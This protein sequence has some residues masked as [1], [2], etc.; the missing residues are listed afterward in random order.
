M[1]SFLFV[2]E[3]FTIGG[4]ET[5]LQGEMAY[6]SSL[7]HEV[8]LATGGSLIHSLLPEKLSSVTTSLNFS[9][10]PSVQSFCETV[11]RLRFLIRSMNVSCVLVHPF[12]PSIPSFIAAALEGVSLKYTVHGPSS[13]NMQPYGYLVDFLFKHIF[14]PHVSEVVCVSE[15]SFELAQ[16]YLNSNCSIVPNAVGLPLGL[17]AKD[18]VDEVD[19]RWLVVSRLESDKVDG[20]F[21]FIVKA[22]KAGIVGVVIVGDGGQRE[23][24]QKKIAAVYLSEFVQ[25]YGF[26]ENAYTLMP[27]FSGVAGIGRVLLEGLFCKKP[28]CSI[29]NLGI[30]GL[31]SFENITIAAAANFSGRNLPVVDEDVFSEQLKAH[32]SSDALR[33][34][35]YVKQHYWDAVVWQKAYNVES[36]PLKDTLLTQLYFL[37][38][39]ESF[40]CEKECLLFSTHV[41]GLI[42]ELV[43]SPKYFTAQLSFA[44]EHAEKQ[45]TG[46]ESGLLT[47]GSQLITEM[48]S[49]LTEGLQLVAEMRSQL[50]EGL[51]LVAETRSQLT[52]ELQLLIET[53]GQFTEDLRLLIEARSQFVENLQLLTETRGRFTE[54]LQLLTEAKNHLAQELNTQKKLA[55]QELQNYM[56]QKNGLEQSLMHSQEQVAELEAKIHALLSSN[57]WQVTGPFR[58]VRRTMGGRTIKA[59]IRAVAKAIYTRLPLSHKNK[60]ALKNVLLGKRPVSAAMIKSQPTVPNHGVAYDFLLKNLENTESNVF[61]FAVIDW[62]FRMQRPQH[63]AKGLAQCGKRVFYFSN[64]FVN[65]AEPGYELERLDENAELYQIKLHVN[66]APAIYFAGPSQN[67][68]NSIN[69]SMSKFLIDFGIVSSIS[70]VQHA[71]WYPTANGLPNNFLMYDCMDHHEGFG[72]VPQEIIELEHKLL[73]T[74]NSVIT[75]SSWLEDFAKGHNPNVVTIRNA[76]EYGHFATPP[77]EVF[78]D[79]KGRKIIG[80]FGAIAEWFDVELVEKVARHFPDCLVL[81]IGNDTINAGKQLNAPNIELVGEVPYHKLPYY[82]HAFDVCLLPFLVIPLTLATNPVKVYEYLSAGKSVVSVDLPELSQFEGLVRVAATHDEFAHQIQLALNDMPLS[83]DVV[84]ARQ[85]FAQQQTWRLRTEKLLSYINNCQSPK[86]SIVVVT[87][88]N[89]E[90]T[91]NCLHS[92]D[93]YSDYAN[94]EIIVVDN[95][96][97]DGSDQFLKEWVLGANNRKLILNTDNKG[98]SAANNQGIALAS[99]EYCVLLNNDT[100]VTPGWIRT[101]LSCFQSDA[102]TGIVG[103]VTNN[104]GNEAKID[105]SYATMSEMLVQSML[106]TRHHIGSKKNLKVLAFFCV[107][108]SRKLVE[109]IGVLDEAFGQGFFEDDDYCRRAEQA[110]YRLVCAENVFVHHHLSASFNKLKQH[111]RQ[112]LFERNKQIYEAKWGEWLP[113]QHRG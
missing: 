22:K 93:R 60:Q 94:K 20:V 32:Q 77:Q 45:S 7:G 113:H 80:Y 87:Y 66:G 90:L 24:L 62:H 55:E 104:I 79:P 37:L 47:K 34:F 29:G 11:E 100:Y 70:I 92:I 51:Q 43:Y 6:L 42:G 14:L 26:K 106:F 65:S 78:V 40:N 59:R 13:L 84:Q 105:I 103:P 2:T 71:Y 36:A 39:Q 57:S 67:D 12:T 44:Y 3:Q 56:A 16:P 41:W 33:L 21:D 1:K 53:R 31:V 111:D 10:N 88:N 91:K 72:N 69:A 107:M 68:I 48:R 9:P 25:F 99:G 30:N 8:H 83:N 54:D 15:E 52:E 97:T 28:V 95:Q 61:V 18:K 96:S 74:S 17:D 5:R 4:V 109:E 108:F 85:H 76:T 64:H 81:L 49:Q 19:P 38:K 46:A 50:T 102:S 82:L 73:A 35:E 86:V 58:Y 101:M 112:A 63:L 27:Y 89:L 75:T 23:S 98:F 110:G